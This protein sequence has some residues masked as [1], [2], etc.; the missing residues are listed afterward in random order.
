MIRDARQAD[1]RADIYSLGATLYYLLTGGPPFQGTSLYD[2]LQAHRS[3]DATPLN[4]V[5]PEVPVEL[6][7]LVAKMMVKEPGSR[8][9][10]SSEVAEALA[11]F[12]EPGA[13]SGY[14]SSP[15]ASGVQ[16]ADPY[17]AVLCGR[18]YPNARTR[19][20]AP[21]P[22]FDGSRRDAL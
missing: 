17:P 19:P 3:V 11:P 22:S 2:I 15:N 16:Q 4:L 18:R 13:N 7:A 20:R 6:A 21:S 12:L 5:R 14:G 1:I 8:F 10:A 9:Q